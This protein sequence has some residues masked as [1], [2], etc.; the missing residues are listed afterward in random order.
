MLTDKVARFLIENPLNAYA[1]DELKYAIE[2]IATLFPVPTAQLQGKREQV[3][4]I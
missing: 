2:S 1:A 3:K 4:L